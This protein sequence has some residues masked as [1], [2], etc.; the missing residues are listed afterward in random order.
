MRTLLLELR[1]AALLELELDDL[2]RQL[3]EAVA[4]RARLPVALTVEGEC[5][6]Q[7]DVQITLY[8]IA[9]EALNN[10][11]KHAKATQA[12]VSLRFVPLPLSTNDGERTAHAEL[13]IDD[14]GRGFDPE[15]VLPDC[16]GL[17]I[18]RERAEAV[19]ADVTIESQVGRGTHL[20]VTWSDT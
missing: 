11:V 6:L 4:G 19:G 15:N 10:V 1:P 14:D 12:S 5:S 8:R 2:L 16:L 13:R 18:M 17:Q 3:V 7:P 9:Q 20:V